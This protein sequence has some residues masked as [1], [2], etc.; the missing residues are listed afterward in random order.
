M[1]KRSKNAEV[2]NTPMEALD[3]SED[4]AVSTA[5]EPQ[6]AAPPKVKPIVEPPNDVWDALSPDD[7]SVP[8]ESVEPEPAA[9]PELEPELLSRAQ[10]F[11]IGPDE[12]K[13]LGSPDAVRAALALADR[14][15]GR[16]MQAA[17]PAAQPVAESAPQGREKP[18][19]SPEA[20]PDADELD[21]NVY[22]EGLVKAYKALKA[23]VLQLEASLKDV[24]SAT[25][26]LATQRSVAKFDETLRS[27]GPEYAELFGDGETDD[28]DPQSEQFKN[29]VKVAMTVKALRSA[30]QDSTVRPPTMA[31]LVKRAV[32]AEFSDVVTKKATEEGAK[33][34][35]NELGQYTNRPNGRTDTQPLQSADDRALAALERKWRQIYGRQ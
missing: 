2:A 28:L 5:K 25:A 15:I 21:P 23:R 10:E 26:G 32:A 34:A 35:R 14:L 11:G 24:G 22:D 20:P 27:L 3:S 1:G 16:R 13:K 9:E 6:P 12:A 30:Y 31:A 7:V 18:T 8:A 4:V 33:R 17:Q 19:T 29:R